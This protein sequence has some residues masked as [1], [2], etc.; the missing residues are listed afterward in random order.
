[1]EEEGKIEAL[2]QTKEEEIVWDHGKTIGDEPFL[3]GKIRGKKY[4]SFDEIAEEQ[5]QRRESLSPEEKASEAAEAK[6]SQEIWEMKKAM[7]ER[8]V[9]QEKMWRA[10][11]DGREPRKLLPSKDTDREKTFS[12]SINEFAER[13][14]KQVNLCADAAEIKKAYE[15]LDGE[16][17]K[18]SIDEY[19][20]KINAFSKEYLRLINPYAKP[21]E[22]KDVFDVY[23]NDQSVD[24][25]TLCKRWCFFHSEPTPQERVSKSQGKRVGRKHKN[26][27]ISAKRELND[28]P[29]SIRK[30]IAYKEHVIKQEKKIA[31]AKRL[32]PKKVMRNSNKFC[33]SRV[34]FTKN[35]IDMVVKNVLP[36]Q[37][38]LS[39]MVLTVLLTKRSHGGQKLMDKFVFTDKSIAKCLWEDCGEE[40]SEPSI[41]HVMKRLRDKG[42]IVNVEC[43]KS[44][45]VVENKEIEGKKGKKLLFKSH[46]T[47]QF[48]NKLLSYF[49]KLGEMA[50]QAGLS[51]K[52]NDAFKKAKMSI[53]R[54]I[55]E[56][57]NIL[58]E[59]PS[60]QPIDDIF[61]Y[62]FTT[63]LI[64]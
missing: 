19:Y 5:K 11:R 16:L 28:L 56:L 18:E 21:R 20:A 57:W 60:R 53:Q 51:T 33:L 12:Q 10:R 55:K 7:R 54:K 35:T 30:E 62:E 25:P 48:T 64:T 41:R 14:H 23:R 4:K 46:R 9:Q 17:P 44:Y 24:L 29:P 22:V 50:Y 6:R 37:A 36:R 13:Y 8:N 1:M 49:F 26:N 31:V 63:M 40:V 27:N 58:Q 52:V 47:L 2:A 59:L 61:R 45:E 38:S 32:H 43:S 39:R 3:F 15:K 34:S 42:L